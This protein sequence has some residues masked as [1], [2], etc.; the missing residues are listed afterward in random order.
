LVLK[1]KLKVGILDERATVE[2]CVLAPAKNV[3]RLIILFFSAVF[4]VGGT[5]VMSLSF[6]SIR[7]SVLCIDVLPF[8]L[9]LVIWGIK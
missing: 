5:N 8:E 7:S 6:F 2:K 4:Y 1:L 9:A 3:I